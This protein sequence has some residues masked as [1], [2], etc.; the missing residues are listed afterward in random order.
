M[1]SGIPFC[2]EEEDNPPKG[3]GTLVIVSAEYFEA[4]Q[5]LLL[6]PALD[7]LLELDLLLFREISPLFISSSLWTRPAELEL[8]GE[9]CTATADQRREEVLLLV[10]DDIGT[11]D[12]TPIEALAVDK[13]ILFV[14]RD[15]VD[16]ICDSS[17]DVV[18]V[19]RTGAVANFV[20]SIDTL[21][22]SASS[23]S[24]LDLSLSA[25]SFSLSNLARSFSTSFSLSASLWRAAP[26]S[27]SAVNSSC[28]CFSSS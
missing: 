13:S 9:A 23:F 8:M 7:A 17:S 5:T 11:V 3:V 21:A 26:L 18:G 28:L 2:L 22:V 14:A 24:L 25:I 10:P 16:D 20:A 4:V 12:F 27:S 15:M 6:L 19:A 1:D